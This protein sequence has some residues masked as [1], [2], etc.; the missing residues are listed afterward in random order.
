MNLFVLLIMILIIVKIILTN[1]DDRENILHDQWYF[2]LI[3]YTFLLKQSVKIVNSSVMKLLQQQLKH[4]DTFW[5][6]NGLNKRPIF[7]DSF[8]NIGMY[9]RVQKF[10][11]SV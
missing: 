7:S 1:L 5:L 11:T 8:F 4:N 3:S 6:S 9:S 10:L 2:G